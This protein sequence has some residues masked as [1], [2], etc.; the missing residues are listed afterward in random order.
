MEGISIHAC[1]SQSGNPITFSA[2]GGGSFR[3]DCDDSQIANLAAM[4]SLRDV[5]L[6]VTVEADPDGTLIQRRGRPK[7]EA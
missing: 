3:F 1:L 5:P 6:L 7:K 4:L 2:I